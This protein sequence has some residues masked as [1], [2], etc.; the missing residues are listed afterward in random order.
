MSYETLATLLETIAH[1]LQKQAG[2]LTGTKLASQAGKLESAAARFNKDLDASLRGFDP[3]ALAL[4]EL[5]ESDAGRAALDAGALKQLAKKATGKSVTVKKTD[6][7]QDARARL[8]DQA[9]KLGRVPETLAAVTRHLEASAAPEPPLDNRD[10]MLE[11]VWELGRLDGPDLNLAK[12]SL[13]KNEKVLRAMAAFT[14][15][16]TT[17]RS[18]PA[19]MFT[20][21]VKFARR[22]NENVS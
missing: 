7:P 5:M 8:V 15:I 17:P 10:A 11:R 12:S 22:V 3:E 21:I 13:L 6:E 16:R 19:S 18:T 4:R 20:A 1:R 14:H 2:H 9:I